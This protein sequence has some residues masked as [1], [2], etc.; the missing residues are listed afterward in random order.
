MPPSLVACCWCC[1][2]FLS[3]VWAFYIMSTDVST[4][5]WLVK[6]S[7]IFA[8]KKIVLEPKY[9]EMI[10]PL[11]VVIGIIFENCHIVISY[12]VLDYESAFF[13]PDYYLW[14]STTLFTTIQKPIGHHHR[15]KNPWRGFFQKIKDYM[16]EGVDVRFVSMFQFPTYISFDYN[17][18]RFETI[19]IL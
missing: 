9:L 7:T 10:A 6:E 12:V 13:G 1:P 11:I 19:T 3:L 18:L 14:F 4:R 5:V 17:V 2:L 16:R 8:L 15:N